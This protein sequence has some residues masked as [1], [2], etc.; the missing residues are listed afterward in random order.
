METNNWYHINHVEALDSP[1]LV[2][3]PKRVKQ[4]IHTAIEM[5]GDVK[6][7][8]PHIKTNKSAEVARLMIEA[9]ITKFKC[10]TIAEAEMLGMSKA[11][12]VLLAYQPIGPKIYRFAELIKKYPATNFSC[13]T[14]HM[15]AA[16]QMAAFFAAH[17]IIV[18]VYIDLN[19]GQ[20]RT[21][22]SPSESFELF[23]EC[24]TMPGI[25]PVGLHEYDGHIRDIDWDARKKK[26]D[27]AFLQVEKLRTFPAGPQLPDVIEHALELFGESGCHD[28]GTWWFWSMNS[29]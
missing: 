12:D 26:C 16:N 3:Y 13:L 14:D 22:I 5:I 23:M 15:T 19:V 21:G 17:K 25:K 20:N 10:A 8:R 1:S 28:I 24:S 18:P 29:Q 2:I 4:N 7:L 11:K 6:R 9:G 27:E